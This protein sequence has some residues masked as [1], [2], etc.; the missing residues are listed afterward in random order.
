MSSSQWRIKRKLAIDFTVGVIVESLYD[1]SYDNRS[2]KI[3]PESRPS[4][5]EVPDVRSE[6]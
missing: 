2:T 6:I 4:S 1:N 5:G 3:S